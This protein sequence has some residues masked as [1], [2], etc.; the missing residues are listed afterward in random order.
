[1]I[2]FLTFL[3]GMVCIFLVIMILMQAGR[4]GGLTEAFASAESI[5]GAQ[6]SGFLVKTTTVLAALFLVISLSLAFMSSN[7][8]QS[9]MSN[10]I[11]AK[12]ALAESN[13]AEKASQAQE[14]KTSEEQSSQANQPQDTQESQDTPAGDIKTKDTPQVPEAS[15]QTA[16]PEAVPTGKNK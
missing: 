6:T 8:T 13:K 14:T 7:K 9:L 5:F 3:H 12:K 10:K 15:T 1:M 2:G 4:G 11:T 16:V